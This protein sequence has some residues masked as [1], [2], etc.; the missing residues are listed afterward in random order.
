MGDKAGDIVYESKSFSKIM[1]GEAVDFLC[2][3]IEATLGFHKTDR[4]SNGQVADTL[5][6]FLDE[7]VSSK[8][9]MER[10]KRFLD[11]NKESGSL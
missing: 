11:E 8:E 7:Q 10:L 3:A 2:D 5:L 6:R 1:R 9:Q 4:L